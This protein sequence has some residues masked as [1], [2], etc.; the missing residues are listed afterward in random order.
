VIFGGIVLFTIGSLNV[1]QG[2]VALFKDD[3]NVITE[4]GL[5]VSTNFTAWGI[6]LIIWGGVMI[7]AGLGLSSGKEWAR[8]SAIIVVVINLIGQFAYF[9]AFP[10]WSLIVIGLDAAVLFALTARWQEARRGCR[11]RKSRAGRVLDGLTTTTGP[12]LSEPASLVA[13]VWAA[14]RGRGAQAAGALCAGGAARGVRDR[15]GV[16]QPGGRPGTGP[17]PRGPLVSAPRVCSGTAD[18]VAGAGHEQPP[19]RLRRTVRNHRFRRRNHG[20]GN[21]R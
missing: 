5:I 18:D 10:L 4:A 11:N 20:R 2:L 8:W 1:I 14:H 16:R 6:G 13:D 19:E 3:V 21:D 9:P 15:R 12:A 17:M 7:L